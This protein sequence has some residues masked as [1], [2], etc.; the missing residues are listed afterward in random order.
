MEVTERVTYKG[1]VL[2]PLAEDELL[3]AA[4]RLMDEQVEAIAVCFLHAYANP[5]H[6]ARAARLIRQRWP[7]VAVTASHELTREWREDERTPTP[8]RNSHMKTPPPRGPDP[9]NPPPTRH[10][11][12]GGPPPMP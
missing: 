10:R 6:E 5:T 2:V 1:E 7:N 11:G 3:A 9:L 4:T 8:G 12:G